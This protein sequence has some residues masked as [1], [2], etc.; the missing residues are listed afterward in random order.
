MKQSISE[1]SRF[2]AAFVAGLGFLVTGS[3]GGASAEIRAAYAVETARCI[4]NERAIVDRQDST[5][6][7]D[8]RD[9]AAERAR[10]DE[11]LRAIESGGGR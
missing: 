5:R 11:A 3:C 4:A 2:L 7:Q 8:E 1:T 6:E 9:L 10:C